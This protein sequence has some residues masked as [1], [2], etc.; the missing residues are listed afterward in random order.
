MLTR[1]N[2]AA[3]NEPAQR[4]A[5]AFIELAQLLEAQAKRYRE[6]ARGYR[7]GDLLPGYTNL[8]ADAHP[9]MH[10]PVRRAIDNLSAYDIREAVERLRAEL[11]A[12]Q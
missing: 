11:E 8:P 5:D 10:H 2:R 1:R 6:M 3:K 7:T 4:A 12:G 9:T